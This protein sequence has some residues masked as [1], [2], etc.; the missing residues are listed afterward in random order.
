LII[1]HST[2]TATEDS[3]KPRGTFAYPLNTGFHKISTWI[4]GKY[5]TCKLIFWAFISL[6]CKI[7]NLP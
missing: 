5:G 1:F 3:N 2:N 4:F 7:L 6:S